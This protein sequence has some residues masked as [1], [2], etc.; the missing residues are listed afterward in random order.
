VK[1]PPR[2]AIV[3][4]H[5]VQYYAP[6]FRELATA[7]PCVRVFYL[8]DGGSAPRHDPG[9]GQAIQWDLDLLSGYEHEFVA[10]TS[11][12]PGTARPDGL[13]NPSLSGRLR[14]WRPDAVLVFGYGWKS[15]LRLALTWRFCP[16]ILRGDTHL[17]GRD[18]P[19]GW[20]QR[21]RQRLMPVLL[22]RYR[23][24]AS[25]GAAHT[26]FLI[27]NGVLRKQIFHV[28]HCVDNSRW[29]E[30]TNKAAANTDALRERL[31]IVRGQRVIVFAGKF[32]S[33]K[34]PDL[35]IEA[36]ARAA[37]PKTTLL[38]VGAGPLEPSLRKQSEGMANVRFLPFQNQQSLPSIFAVADFLVLPSE[39]P[40]ETWGLVVN[41]AMAAGLPC[42]VSDHV[43][44]RE[45]LVIEGVT[46][47][48]FPHGDTGALAS[49]LN[50]AC[51]T[52]AER[53][54]ELR[55]A[56]RDHIARYD[57]ASATSALLAALAAVSPSFRM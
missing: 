22:G 52:V 11:R 2:L 1:P 8:W 34:R 6:W 48:S 23:G 56:V 21:F 15:L 49:K 39:G 33:K 30:Q 16:L 4:S 38:M 46:G 25:V 3:A 55:A 40:E 54:P 9:F 20:R 17:I 14:A 32:E 44:C 27:K 51:D 28:P 50:L 29:F 12:H 35:L 45:D 37:R 31:G 57:Y 5:P 53:G 47:W 43:G 36:F 26:R 24:F 19:S 7:C 42:I 10:N 41:E 13:D 18:S